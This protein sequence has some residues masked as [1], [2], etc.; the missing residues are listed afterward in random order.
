MRAIRLALSLSLSVCHARLPPCRQLRGSRHTEAARCDHCD[1]VCALCPIHLS[2]RDLLR[3]SYGMPLTTDRSYRCIRELLSSCHPRRPA[4]EPLCTSTLVRRSRTLPRRGGAR[5][6]S[7]HLRCHATTET[8]ALDGSLTY[9]DLSTSL[10]PDGKARHQNSHWAQRGNWEKK[11]W[12][13]QGG[14]AK[15]A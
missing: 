9:F 2:P 8:G 15:R 10:F 14:E 6:A 4:A 1:A 13:T 11:R 3:P 5:E 12:G 7:L